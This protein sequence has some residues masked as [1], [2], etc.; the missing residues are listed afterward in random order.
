MDA[1][2]RKRTRERVYENAHA[3]K[4]CV[5]GQRIAN[6]AASEIGDIEYRKRE[7]NSI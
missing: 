5:H 7:D 3:C 4:A 2:A 6:T 1:Y